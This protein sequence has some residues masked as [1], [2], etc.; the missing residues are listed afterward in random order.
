MPIILSPSLSRVTRLAVAAAPVAL[1]DP[2]LRAPDN[3]GGYSEAKN[4]SVLAVG[5][6]LR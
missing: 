5:R 2:E 6:H 3:G 4:A 1:R